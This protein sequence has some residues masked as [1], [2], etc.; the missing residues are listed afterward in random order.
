MED[1]SSLYHW[2]FD[3]GYCC[4]TPTTCAGGG[5]V[6]RSHCWECHEFGSL[7]RYRFPM[8]H[9]TII[10]KFPPK[11]LYLKQYDGAFY[12]RMT[13]FNRIT[14][15]QPINSSCN[16][17]RRNSIFVPNLT[18]VFCFVRGVKRWRI[19]HHSDIRNLRCRILCFLM[20]LLIPQ[21]PQVNQVVRGL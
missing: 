1:K 8:E 19:V 12:I 15:I 10:E 21:E 20:Y 9:P 4:V 13:L 6:L 17:I 14:E 2:S 11:R 7:S 16:H 3:L 5:C 18:E